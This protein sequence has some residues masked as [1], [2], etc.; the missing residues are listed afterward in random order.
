MLIYND[1]YNCYLKIC[2]YNY[3]TKF[4]LILIALNQI[5]YVDY[6]VFIIFVANSYQKKTNIPIMVNHTSICASSDMKILLI[7]CTLWLV[8]NYELVFSVKVTYTPGN[9]VYDMTKSMD[10]RNGC[11]VSFDSF[12]FDGNSGPLLTYFDLLQMEMKTFV[13]GSCSKREEA[14]VAIAQ[15]FF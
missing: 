11:I 7:F 9:K 1:R 10:I 15:Q 3:I 4:S 5:Q 8:V 14:L 6:R 13:I 2:I 12:R